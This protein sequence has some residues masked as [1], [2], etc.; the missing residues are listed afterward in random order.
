MYSDIGPFFDMLRM[1]KLHGRSSSS[2]W[3]WDKTVVGIITNS[4]DRVP[5]IL[6]SFGLKVC[7]RRVGTRD[8][9][10][11]DD[12]TLKI[13]DDISFTVLSYDV[14]FEKPDQRIFDAAVDMLEET[15]ADDQ[16]AL[17]VDDFEKLYIG[18]DVEKDYEGAGAAGW[19]RILLRRGSKE[20]EEDLEEKERG[21]LETIEIMKKNKELVSVVSAQSLQALKQF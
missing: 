10:R 9:R 21:Q 2:S 8:Q 6:N 3:K 7:P 12:A 13:D 17:T 5:S 1:I 16:I 11:R 20:E 14:G 15:L 19:N 18:D 4:D